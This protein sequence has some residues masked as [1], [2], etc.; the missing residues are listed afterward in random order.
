GRDLGVTPRRRE[1]LLGQRRRIVAVNEVMRDA[2]MIG[3]LGADRLENGGGLALICGGLVG[4][5]RRRLEGGPIEN[6][7][8]AV[9]GEAVV[10][11]R[12]RLLIGERPRAMVARSEILVEGGDRLDV[13]TLALGLGAECLRLRGGARTRPQRLLAW[14]IPEW[15]PPAHGDTPLRHGAGA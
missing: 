3:H 1:P 11:L 7:R 14:R 9:L 13:A 10:Q 2:G 4:G 5:E 6:R 8:L 12:H 15:V